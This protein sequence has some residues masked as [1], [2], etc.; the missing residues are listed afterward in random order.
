MLHS[1]TKEHERYGSLTD[2][3][4]DVHLAHKYDGTRTRLV[5]EMWPHSR[6]RKM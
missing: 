2:P 5:I 6:P 1:H 3:F 4:R